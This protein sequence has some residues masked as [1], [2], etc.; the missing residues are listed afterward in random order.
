MTIVDFFSLVLWS[1]S[2]VIPSNIAQTFEKD[3]VTLHVYRK[4]LK[5]GRQTKKMLPALG[6]LACC[7]RTQGAGAGPHEAYWA[8]FRAEQRAE[9]AAL[10]R[11]EAME[12]GAE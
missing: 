2:T 4:F 7:R 5:T 1:T 11:G 6:S 3:A 12:G 8:A 10:A 9:L